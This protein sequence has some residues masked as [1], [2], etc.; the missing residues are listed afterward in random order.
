[1]PS[2]KLY[3]R[4]RIEELRSRISLMEA[5]LKELK[6]DFQGV[7]NACSGKHCPS[8]LF[9]SSTFDKLNSILKD[10]REGVDSIQPDGYVGMTVVSINLLHSVSLELLTE[11]VRLQ[12][13]L[14]QRIS[15][16]NSMKTLELEPF[17]EMEF[18]TIMKSYNAVDALCFEL[19]EKI[20]GIK[21]IKEHNYVPLSLFDYLNYQINLNSLIISIP[22]YDSYRCR[23]WASLAHEVSH[24]LV[25]QLSD[26]VG[27]FRDVMKDGIDD[28]YSLLKY[29]KQQ[30]SYG[31]K[32]TGIQISELTSDIISTYVC[33]P[34]FFTAATIIHIPTEPAPDSI[35]QNL[36]GLSHPNTD[37]RLAAM[38]TVLEINGIKEGKAGSSI[39]Q[40]ATGIQ[41]FYIRKNMSL[42]STQ[43][44]ANINKLNNFARSYARKVLPILPDIGVKGFTSAD[45]QVVAESVGNPSFKIDDFTPIQLLIFA[46]LKRI[47]TTEKDDCLPMERFCEHRRFESKT[48]ELV[49]DL[50][51]KYY[52]EH[53]VAEIKGAD[54]K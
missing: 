4:E 40:A 48:F 2:F 38:D 13:V 31:E 42:L 6:L 45:L 7:N 8:F 10:L 36:Q 17:S 43:S 30:K 21:W 27:D 3:T 41:S 51:Y 32:I 18:G 34:A 26:K 5:T 24:I 33:P 52:E 1:M 12:N 11:I 9:P 15:G 28:L 46:W 39:K 50:M 25:D 22:F 35:L 54:L 23:F 47:N 14:S 19:V 37:M 16:T 53:M 20:L 49:V 29:K 44:F